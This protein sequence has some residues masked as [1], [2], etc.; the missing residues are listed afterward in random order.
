MPSIACC[1]FPTTLL[2]LDDDRDLLKSIQFAF[3][4][5][6]KCICTTN[7]VEA[8]DI[9]SKNRGWTTCLL[10]KGISQVF[11][12]ED[13]SLFSLSMDVLLLKKQIHNPNRFK[14][15]AIAIVDYDM[16]K[17]N[18][19][20]FIQELEDSQIK[21]IM[22]T[23]KASQETVI[24]AFN[25]R[26]IHRY[27]SKGDVDYIGKISKYINELQSEFFL[28]FSKFILDAL[29][30]S[31]NRVFENKSFIDEFN[32]IV[33][34]NRI[35]EYYLLDESGSFILLDATAQNQIWFIVKSKDE[36]EHFYEITS[37]DPE[38]KTPA[39]VVEGL[40]NRTLLTHFKTKH[41][42]IAPVTSWHFLKAQPLDEKNQYFYAI[43]KNDKYFQIDSSKIRSYN[44]FLKQG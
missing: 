27:V 30:E 12:E 39:D 6:Y 41:E 14:H 33:L 37:D 32:K 19:L 16:P 43:T 11:A 24:A 34:E 3:S 26:K 36:M 2:I 38:M 31:G 29:K 23:G 7:P 15:I 44:D 17:K 42:K 21:V 1:S 4:G 35:V 9:L 20:E 8:H 28:D 13:P 40:K 10:E 18:G 5:K 22:L 25:D